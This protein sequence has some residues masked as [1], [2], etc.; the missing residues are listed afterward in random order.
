[1]NATIDRSHAR[2]PRCRRVVAVRVGDPD[3]WSTD[4]YRRHAVAPGGIGCDGS[5]DPVMI[6]TYKVAAR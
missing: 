4:R 6:G 3:D 5:G 1:M 2:C